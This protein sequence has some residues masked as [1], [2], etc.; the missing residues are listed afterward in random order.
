M[1]RRPVAH[2]VVLELDNVTGL[3]LRADALPNGQSDSLEITA[4]EEETAKL[5]IANLCDENPLF[6]PKSPV[7]KDDE[8]FRWHFELL[9][10]A[11]KKAIKKYLLGSSLPIPRPE[12]IPVTPSATGANC[13]KARFPA[14]G[15]GF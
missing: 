7:P 10:D 2:E 15:S 13:F 3:T 14:I 9:T 12:M 1:I 8:D 11:H 4:P 6:W 5:T